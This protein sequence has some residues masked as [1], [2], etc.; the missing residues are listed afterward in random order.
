MR[1]VR[2]LLF[3]VLVLTVVTA[4]IGLWFMSSKEETSPSGNAPNPSTPEGWQ[5]YAVSDSEFTFDYPAEAEVKNTDSGVTVSYLGPD[6]ATG[7]ITD[8]YNVQF[9]TD[10]LNGRSLKEF[11][12]EHKENEDG[13]TGELLKQP[14]LSVH[15]SY[16]YTTKEANDAYSH[17]Y[18]LPSLPSFQRALVI[19]SYVADPNNNDY[20]TQIQKIRASAWHYWKHQATEK[21]SNR[22]SIEK[23]RA[24]LSSAATST[25]LLP[26]LDT[27]NSLVGI[28]RGCD[29]VVPQNVSINSP[30]SAKTPLTAT[31]SKFFS[32]NTENP[33]SP[34]DSPKD[35]TKVNLLHMIGRMDTLEFDRVEYSQ[36][37][38]HVYLTGELSGLRG[39][40]D[41][42]RAKIQIE[43][44]ALQFP[45]IHSVNIYLNGE[46]TDLQPDARGE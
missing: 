13:T 30:H 9:R 17:V 37:T 38:A 8:G 18:I 33:V 20:R 21:H 4:G 45:S 29:S 36:G 27:S 26:L 41:N 2:S 24:S 43:E 16:R 32:I 40:C 42:P 22:S 14:T 35:D 39:V 7:R 25:V 11:A 23:D 31:Y 19:K 1:T 10:S 28:R 34:I 6:N 12:Q 15:L 46:K 3:F 44:A 5:T